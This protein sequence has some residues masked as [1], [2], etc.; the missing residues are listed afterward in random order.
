MARQY[1]DLLAAVYL[2]LDVANKYQ[3]WP[4]ILSKGLHDLIHNPACW[5]QVGGHSY[6]NA[7]ACDYA[8]PP[9]IMVQLAVLLP[10][11]DYI[12]WGG[13]ELEVMKKIMEGLPFFYNKELGTIMRWHPFA[14]VNWRVKK[15]KKNHW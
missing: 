11:Q 7:Y 14:L 10:L 2:Q 9:E 5:S 4:E 1:L 13:H 3:P 6:L 12:E 15:S 8:T